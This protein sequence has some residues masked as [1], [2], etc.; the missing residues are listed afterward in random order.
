[1]AAFYDGAPR[2]SSLLSVPKAAVFTVSALPARGS[3]T[4]LVK[5]GP[6]AQGHC[7][8]FSAVFLSLRGGDA[9]L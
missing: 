2:L 6:P 9:P 8:L 1:M 5:A 3:Y 7:T 4:T